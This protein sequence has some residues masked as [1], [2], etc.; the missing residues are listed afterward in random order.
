MENVK[1]SPCC[2]MWEL[3]LTIHMRK[4]ESLELKT[5]GDKIKAKFKIIDWFLN[6]NL[7]IAYWTPIMMKK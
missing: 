4:E 5:S 1:T 6:C 2:L 3:C 7:K